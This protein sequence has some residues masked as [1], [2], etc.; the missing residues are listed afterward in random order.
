MF[1]LVLIAIFAS[2]KP[3]QAQHTRP[4]YDFNYTVSDVESGQQFGQEEARRGENTSGQYQVQLPD[5]RVQLVTYSVAD[6]EAGYLATV[7]YSGEA[8][9]APFFTPEQERRGGRGGHLRP[10]RLSGRLVA[11]P[12]RVGRPTTRPQPLVTRSPPVAPARLQVA[13]RAPP[14]APVAPVAPASP[15]AVAGDARISSASE[16]LEQLER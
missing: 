9:P 15:V 4:H 14:P 6:P 10:D 11:R 7:S 13:T 12:S 2:L 8:A 5:G 3:L 1:A 16:K